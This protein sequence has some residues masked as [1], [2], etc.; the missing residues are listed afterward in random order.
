MAFLTVNNLSKSYGAQ[1]VFQNLRF[2]VHPGERVGI[3]GPNGAGKTTLLR[4]LTGQEEADT[5]EFVIPRGITVG[6]LEQSAHMDSDRT[7]EEE[8]RRAF[9][10]LDDM[11][12]EIR[13]LEAQMAAAPRDSLPEIMERYAQLCHRFEEEG[14]YRAEARLRSVLA[15][16]GF[17]EAD[18]PRP[19]SSF[20]GGERTR[21]QLCRLLLEEPDLLILDEPTNHLDMRSVEWLEETLRSWRGSVL[22]VSHDRFFLDRVTG[23]ILELYRHSL[24]SYPGNYSDYVRQREQ[25]DTAQEKAFKKQ[26][27][28]IEKQ[29]EFIRSSGTGEREKRQARS[30]EKMLARL[31]LTERPVRERVMTV[32]FG[33]AGMSGEKVA[34]LAGVSVSFDEKELFAGLNLELRRGDRV[35]LV[36]PNGAGKSTLLKLITGE[37]TPETGTVRLGPSVIPLYFDQHQDRVSPEATPLAEVME[38]ADMTLTEA[39]TYLG[40]FLFSG[41]DVYKKN[42]TLSGGEKSRLALALLG[43]QDGNFLILDEPTNHLDIMSIEQL[44][45][46]VSHFPGTLLVVSHDRYF[47]SKTTGSILEMDNGRLTWYRMPYE[48]YLLKRVTERDNT[49]AA[50]KE[51][52]NKREEQEK[53]EREALLAARREKRRKIREFEACEEKIAEM[54]KK[55]ADLEAE[56]ATP[57]VFNDYQLSREK[58]EELNRLKKELE[59]LY[60]SWEE[61]AVVVESLTDD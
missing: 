24:K 47:I 21:L 60:E 43:L 4:I 25:Q 16:L 61:L 5:G 41:D 55:V 40:R 28:I 45:E 2:Q 50:Q 46:A 49:Q 3:V 29:S 9:A 22:V 37:L 53:N 31:Q 8:L 42:S 57:E 39:R 11:A 44:E 32:S 33:Y 26:Q 10:G 38:L 36:G 30:R 7:M 56:L 17:S 51:T 34:E 58:A 18:L 27:Q 23:R 14:G 20:S 6:F 35:A 1:T 48:E 54:E 13:K 59:H 15:G 19:V 12:G 52:K